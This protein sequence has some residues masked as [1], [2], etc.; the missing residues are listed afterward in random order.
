M[1]PCRFLPLYKL[2][3]IYKET[4][5]YSDAAKC[6]NEI[7]NKKLKIPSFTVS[8]IKAQAEDYLIETQKHVW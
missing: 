5:Q 2:F 3:E 8:S 7:K 4:A 1:I 6:A